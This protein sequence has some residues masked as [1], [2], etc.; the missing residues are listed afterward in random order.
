MCSNKKSKKIKDK[1]NPKKKERKPKLKKKPQNSRRPPP[2]PPVA[3]Q[4]HGTWQVFVS[5]S[6]LSPHPIHSYWPIPPN[7]SFLYALISMSTERK[8]VNGN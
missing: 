3:P 5:K 1:I 7:P 6:M 2:R 4:R 8:E